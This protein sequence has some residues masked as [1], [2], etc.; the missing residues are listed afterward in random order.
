MFVLVFGKFYGVWW[1]R[2]CLPSSNSERFHSAPYKVDGLY[3]CGSGDIYAYYLHDLMAP[4]P[5]WKRSCACQNPG[6]SSGVI[7]DFGTG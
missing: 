6:S 7:R 4:S 1:Q 3:V 2:V 5:P